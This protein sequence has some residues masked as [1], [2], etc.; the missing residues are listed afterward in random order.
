MNNLLRGFRNIPTRPIL[1]ELCAHYR[2]SVEQH[3][4]R[5]DPEVAVSN[6]IMRGS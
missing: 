2:N 3:P 6:V 5:N 1:K 4:R